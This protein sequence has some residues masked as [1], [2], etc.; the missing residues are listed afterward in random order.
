MPYKHRIVYRVFQTM[1][2][3]E[4]HGGYLGYIELIKGI[5]Y[6]SV[7]TNMT[8]FFNDITLLAT[9]STMVV[10]L[11]QNLTQAIIILHIALFVLWYD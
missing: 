4:K 1:R 7:T 2:F 9:I 11:K 6:I 5:K 10:C 8:P 3:L